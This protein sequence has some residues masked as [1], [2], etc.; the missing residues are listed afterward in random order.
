MRREAQISGNCKDPKGKMFDVCTKCEKCG[1]LFR[2]G[3]MIRRG[4]KEIPYSHEE[5]K[6]VLLKLMEEMKIRMEDMNE[7]KQLL[8]KLLEEV[9]SENE[10]ENKNG[11]V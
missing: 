6:V 8:L 9:N 2:W 7:T 10:K 1:R 4:E 3:I 11:S 5:K